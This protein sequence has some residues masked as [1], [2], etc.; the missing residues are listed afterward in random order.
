MQS[1]QKTIISSEKENEPRDS[2]KDLRG[3]SYQKMAEQTGTGKGD[4][5]FMSEKKR[6][7]LLLFLVIIEAIFLVI[8]IRIFFYVWNEK[9]AEKAQEQ[10]QEQKESACIKENLGFSVEQVRITLPEN[11]G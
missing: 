3:F 10:Q 6:K 9:K 2:Q 5:R 7:R 8:I 11:L 1:K 4:K